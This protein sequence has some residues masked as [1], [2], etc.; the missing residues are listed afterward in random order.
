[1]RRKASVGVVSLGVTCMAFMAHAQTPQPPAAKVATTPPVTVPTAKKVVATPPA[2]V[3]AARRVIATTPVAPPAAPTAAKPSAPAPP[4]PPGAAP[5]SVERARQGVVVVE[6]Q[7]KPLALG[8][9]LEGDGRILSALSPLSNGN[10][11]TARYADGAIVP[12]KLAH[13]DRGWD[14]AL[15]SAVATP[16]QPLHLAGLRAASTPSFVGLQ[17]FNL[18]PPNNVTAVPAALTLSP[19]M[20]GGDAA[21]L[22]GAYEVGQKPALVGGPIVNSEG[23]VVAIVARACP[24]GGNAACVPAPYGAPVSALKQF[25]QRVPTEATWLGVEVASDEANGVH[26]VRVVSIVPDSPAAAAGIRP[27]K[28]PAQA[29][30]LVAVDGA[31]VATPSAL[32]EAVR[33]RTTGDSVELL[34]YGLGRYRHVSIKPRPAPE[35]VTLPYVAPKPGKPRVPN[36]YR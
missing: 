14:L 6:R 35:L 2:T 36:P 32:N 12:L 11:L 22:A 30:L 9:V 31:P 4:A 5:N 8:A 20:L 21:T 16:K 18:A 25:L 3:P 28:S 24:L 1:M 15:L 29:D 7:G 23:E 10:F 17:S 19:G 27:G 13:S 34:L 33:A 26:G